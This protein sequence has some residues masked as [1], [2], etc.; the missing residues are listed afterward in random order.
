V[1]EDTPV[2]PISPYGWS[3]LM[4]EIM[5]RDAGTDLHHVTLRYFNVA[6]RS[7]AA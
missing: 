3:K 6:A 2:L 7:V 4:T 1:T 5:L